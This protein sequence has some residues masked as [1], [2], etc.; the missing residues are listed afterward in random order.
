MLSVLDLVRSAQHEACAQ[1]AINRGL[2]GDVV[3]EG[4]RIR[5]RRESAGMG[6]AWLRLLDQRS[7]RVSYALLVKS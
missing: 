4:A 1:R 3:G 6:Q 2:L 7:G 5:E